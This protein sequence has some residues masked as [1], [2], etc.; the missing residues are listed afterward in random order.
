MV[1]VGVII[2]QK[3]SLQGIILQKNTFLVVLQF[4]VT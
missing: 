1:L 3:F 4:S 2:S